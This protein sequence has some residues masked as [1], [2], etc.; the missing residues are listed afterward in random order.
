MKKI[1]SLN[2]ADSFVASLVHFP[3]VENGPFNP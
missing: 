2:K 3:G 1:L